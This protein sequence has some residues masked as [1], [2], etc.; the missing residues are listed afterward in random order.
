MPKKKKKKRKSKAEKR[1]KRQRNE[2]QAIFPASYDDALKEDFCK[3]VETMWDEMLSDENKVSEDLTLHENICEFCALG[4]NILLSQQSIEEAQQYLAERIAPK[5]LEEPIITEI[6]NMA[7]EL[8]DEHFPDHQVLIDETTVIM[9]GGKPVIN[10]KFDMEEFQRKV[11]KISTGIPR[12]D[13]FIDREAVNKALEGIPE[14]QTEDA[15]RAEIQRQTDVYNN[16]PQDDLGG[17][18]P[19]EA[20]Q[21]NRKK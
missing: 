1:L 13:D 16:T 7:I 3:I 8:K 17:L 12:M 20:F 6:I 2:S 18:T 11:E 4:W 21:R 19:D 14:D 9:K 5:F 15:F 10:V